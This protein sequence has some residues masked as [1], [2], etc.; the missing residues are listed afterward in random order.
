M[1][2]G[3]GVLLVALALAGCG[4]ST[5]QPPKVAKPPHL[6]RALAHTLAAE[7]NAVAQALEQTDG[8]TALRHA[9]DLRNAVTEAVAAREVP[10]R[11]Q[12]TLTA[13][14]DA[15]PGRIT[16]NPAP[17]EKTKPPKPPKHDHGH[18]HGHGHGPGGGD[19]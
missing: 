6:P 9:N 11:L 2:R 17:P 18:G 5:K 13:A 19:G 3:A 7:A 14:V 10:A 15:L 1:R 16:C 12:P 8:C 4:G